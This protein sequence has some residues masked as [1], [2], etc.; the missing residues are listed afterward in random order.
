MIFIKNHH[1]LTI[2]IK[3]HYTNIT[4]INIFIV[5]NQINKHIAKNTLLGIMMMML[6]D[7][8]I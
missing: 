1:I 8:Y 7:H 6:L 2:L 4:R 5:I 3:N